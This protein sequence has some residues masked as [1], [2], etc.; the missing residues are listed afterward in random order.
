M[1]H[2]RPAYDTSNEE[3]SS[4]IPPPKKPTESDLTYEVFK[5][6]SSQEPSSGVKGGGEGCQ[7][8]SKEL[9]KKEKKGE[10]DEGGKDLQSSL[11]TWFVYH[12][13]ISLPYEMQ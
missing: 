6:G 9:R 4:P 2:E 8:T 12:F 1:K 3:A 11:S 13:C 10:G 7:S 5:W